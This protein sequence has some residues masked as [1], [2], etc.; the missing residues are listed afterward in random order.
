MLVL[1]LAELNGLESWGTGIGNSDL[2]AFTK[3][4]VCI[5]SSPEFGTVEGHNLIILKAVCGLRTSGLHWHE[6]LSDWLR[7]MG[8]E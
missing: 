8:F 2:E 5:G 3:E 4:K 1:F 7:Y 6:R